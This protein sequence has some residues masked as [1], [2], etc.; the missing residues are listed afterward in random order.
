MR[1]EIIPFFNPS[2]FTVLE[3]TKGVIIKVM[4]NINIPTMANGIRSFP[5]SGL[6][7]AD[8][9]KSVPKTTPDR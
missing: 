7:I 9:A 6:N 1:P 8:I 2:I 4:P 3:V 5:M